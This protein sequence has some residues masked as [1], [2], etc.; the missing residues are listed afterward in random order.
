MANQ[1]E[2]AKNPKDYN[3]YKGDI[4]LLIFNNTYDFNWTYIPQTDSHEGFGIAILGTE[5]RLCHRRVQL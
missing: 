4:N 1:P 5:R 3:I 2:T